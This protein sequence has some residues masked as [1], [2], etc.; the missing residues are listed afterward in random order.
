MFFQPH[1]LASAIGLFIILLALLGLVNIVVWVFDITSLYEV[2]NSILFMLC[3]KITLRVFIIA[4]VLDVLVAI[5][6]GIKGE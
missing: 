4:F 2:M 1:I 3:S 5:V 6:N